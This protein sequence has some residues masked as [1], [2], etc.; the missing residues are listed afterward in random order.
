MS[1]RMM[2]LQE[3]QGLPLEAWQT[4]NLDEIGFFLGRQRTRVIVRRGD[5]GAQVSKFDK[6]DHVSGVHECEQQG[7]L[8][9]SFLTNRSS[10]RRSL[11]NF[12][13]SSPSAASGLLPQMLEFLWHIWRMPHL[14]RTGHTLGSHKLRTVVPKL[15][16]DNGDHLYRINRRM[17]ELSCISPVSA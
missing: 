11:A 14:A 1:N 13:N 15:T 2:H 7:T 8:R 6:G 12:C 16:L 17:R 4:H 9:S 3:Q 10:S 5:K